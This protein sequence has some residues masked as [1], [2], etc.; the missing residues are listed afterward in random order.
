MTSD[1]RWG[2]PLARHIN[3]M[4]APWLDTDI[5]WWTPPL[6]FLTTAIDKII[7]DQ[8]AGVLLAPDWESAPWWRLLSRHSD[9]SMRIRS[10]AEFVVPVPN[11]IAQPEVL[12][13]PRWHFRLW[14]IIGSPT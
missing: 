11:N 10:I 13:N 3:T 6:N 1:S 14:L 5:H 7:R 9:S 12:A 8:V 2:S 4:I